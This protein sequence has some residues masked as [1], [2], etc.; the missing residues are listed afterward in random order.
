[1]RKIIYILLFPL[2]WGCDSILD[3]EPENAITFT[4]FFKTEEDFNAMVFQ[5]EGFF[6]Y[7]QFENEVMAYRGFLADQ[8]NSSYYEDQRML[9]QTSLL[10]SFSNSWKNHYDLIYVANVILDNLYRAEGVPQ[11]KLDFY[12]GQA[13]FVKGFVYFDLARKWGDAVITKNSTDMGV[14][15]KSSMLDVLDEAIKNTSEGYKLLPKYEACFVKG[16]VYFDLARKWGDAV[17]TKNS[18][19]MGVYD[20]SSMLDV[21]DEAIKNTSEGYKLLPKYEDMPLLGVNTWVS[22]QYGCKGSCAALLAHLYAWKGSMIELCGLEGDAKKCYEESIEWST[23]L[24][25]K[26]VGFYELERTSEDVCTK[27]MKGMGASQEN[28]LEFELDRFKDYPMAYFPGKSYM[29]W[30]VRGTETPGSVVTKTFVIKAETVKNLYENRDGRRDEY[31]YK[32]DSMSHDTMYKVNQGYAYVYKWREV[33][34]ENVSWSPTPQIA[35]VDANYSYWR[36]ADIYLLR[37]ECYAKL[38][39][40]LAKADLN[41]IR[42]RA[43]ATPYPA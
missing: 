14:Y 34:Y 7:K 13:C 2:L 16:F 38:N 15:D 12:A 22:K 43:N 36:L 37:A 32:L 9:N 39:D 33:V 42:D 40:D 21:L 28:I 41:K 5:M 24:I 1:M 18:T 8:V 27:A 23:L 17:I 4:N 19:D 35:Y 30:P 31:F 11:D 20:K 25:E 6:R 10:N 29:T 3:V 26:K